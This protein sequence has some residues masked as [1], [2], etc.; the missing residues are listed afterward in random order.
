MACSHP[1]APGT[2]G[3]PYVRAREKMPRGTHCKTR[4]HAAFLPATLPALSLPSAGVSP[5]FCAV[6]TAWEHHLG[7]V[8]AVS[9]VGGGLDGSHG[10]DRAG[11]SRRPLHITGP[12]GVGCPHFLGLGWRWHHLRGHW[13]VPFWQVKTPSVHPPRH[14]GRHHGP[15]REAAAVTGSRDVC[16]RRLSEISDYSPPSSSHNAHRRTMQ[17]S[18][19]GPARW[20][21]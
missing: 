4:A 1:Q 16:G 21:P 20:V 2:R 10:A 17:A 7:G 13:G 5:P 3:L 12:P 18:G 9:G 6:E 11:G 19:I 15:L 8:L 14:V